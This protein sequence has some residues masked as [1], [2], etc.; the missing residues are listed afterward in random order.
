VTVASKRAALLAL[1]IVGA[2]W[3]ALGGDAPEEPATPPQEPAPGTAVAIFAGGCF[4]CMEAPFDAVDGVLSTTS[5]YTG[6]HVKNPT[7]EQVSSGTTGHMES[8]RVV[9]DPEKVGY[10]HLLQ[11]FWHNVDPLDAGGQ[12]CDRGS[13]YRSAIFVS[14]ATQRRLAEASLRELEASGRFDRPIATEIREA[15]P[16]Y[17]AEAYHQDYYQRNPIRYRFYR[18]RCGRDARL[19]ELWGDE[20]GH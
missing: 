12:F 20:A 3:A 11:V 7:Y 19:K 4:W 18:S 13:Q 6:G 5:G 16:F 1:L 8:V 2:T 14:D 9:Y 15:G 17:P 10:E